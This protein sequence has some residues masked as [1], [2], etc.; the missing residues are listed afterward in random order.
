ME[1][2]KHLEARIAV[3]GEFSCRHSPLPT[4]LLAEVVRWTNTD[5]PTQPTSREERVEGSLLVGTMSNSPTSYYIPGNLVSSFDGL[6]TLE[7]KNGHPKLP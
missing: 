1:S 5:R 2:N 3:E 6:P 7:L 4:A